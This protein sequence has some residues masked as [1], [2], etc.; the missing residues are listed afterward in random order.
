MLE[1]FMKS[2]WCDYVLPS[3]GTCFVFFPLSIVGTGDKENTLHASLLHEICKK[4]TNKLIVTRLK[5][6]VW[7]VCVCVF[8]RDRN[9]V[10][11]KYMCCVAIQ[12]AECVMAW[13]DECHR[14][15]LLFPSLFFSLPASNS[16][17][18]HNNI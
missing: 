4:R 3:T 8:V 1:Y 15:V 12:N 10:K 16:S 6:Q 7:S 17:N 5:C 14:S 18:N 2:F 9:N 13:H 11:C